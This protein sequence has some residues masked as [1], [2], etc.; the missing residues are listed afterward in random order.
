VLKLNGKT[1]IAPAIDPLSPV[2]ATVATRCGAD[3]V[4]CTLYVGSPAHPALRPVCLVHRIFPKVHAARGHRGWSCPPV[5]GYSDLRPCRRRGPEA[6]CPRSWDVRPGGHT[7]R[8]DAPTLMAASG[9]R[10]RLVVRWWACS[11]APFDPGLRAGIDLRVVVA[12]EPVDDIWRRAIGVVECHD[13]SDPARRTWLRA[14][15]DQLI[16]DFCFHDLLHSVPP[17]S[18]LRGWRRPGGPA[19]RGDAGA[20]D[21]PGPC[22]GPTRGLPVAVAL[23]QQP[24]QDPPAVQRCA[25]QQVEHGE[26]HV[27]QREPGQG[28]GEHRRAVQGAGQE[29]A[30][31]KTIPAA[32]LVAGTAM[33]IC[34]SAAAVGGSPAS[35][36]MLTRPSRMLCFICRSPS[37]PS[38]PDCATRFDRGQGRAS[39]LHGTFGLPAKHGRHPP[40]RRLVNYDAADICRDD[41]GSRRPGSGRP[42]SLSPLCGAPLGGYD[43]NVLPARRASQGRRARAHRTIGP[44]TAD[45]GPLPA[46]AAAADADS[47]A[48]R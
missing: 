5:I 2:I 29:R 30:P 8:P 43:A 22:R 14:F 40:R 6:E 44:G 27:H 13:P 15:D 26:G 7:P 10:R 24:A 35:S 9:H 16:A 23:P 18:M 45:H 1:D 38:T 12:S 42:S 21:L 41:S 34:R 47:R 17:G 20:Q 39:W 36:V 33:A 28:R 11:A 4:G 3:A 32:R 19:D 48:E 37:R 46:A 31:P 25:G